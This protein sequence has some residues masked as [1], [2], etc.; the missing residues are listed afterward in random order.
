[1]IDQIEY[2]TRIGKRGALP[3][4]EEGPAPLPFKGRQTNGEG[5]WGPVVGDYYTQAGEPGI[6]DRLGSAAMDLSRPAVPHSPV[7]PLP[8]VPNQET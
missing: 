8:R 1:M 7:G 2:R 4:R 6:S 5:K 3:I